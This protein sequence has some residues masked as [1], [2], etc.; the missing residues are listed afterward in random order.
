MTEKPITADFFLSFIHYFASRV[1]FSYEWHGCDSRLRLH[2]N[3]CK[4]IDFLMYSP[5]LVFI[6]MFPYLSCIYLKLCNTFDMLYHRL[7]A[8]ELPS[9]CC[10]GCGG[11]ERRGG[12]NCERG[13]FANIITVIISPELTLRRI[14]RRYSRRCFQQYR[15]TQTRCTFPT[16]SANY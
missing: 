3:G 1:V 16:L 9:H 15:A 2:L 13:S 14:L 5:P 11:C 6:A 10:E 8:H 7:H 12:I 4:N